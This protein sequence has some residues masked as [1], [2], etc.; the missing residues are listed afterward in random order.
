MSGSLT[1]RRWPFGALSII[2]VEW[3]SCLPF[4]LIYGFKEGTFCSR[5]E[6][7]LSIF[8]TGEK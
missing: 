5:L 3:L 6:L 7:V 4:M 2:Y 8:D 1:L